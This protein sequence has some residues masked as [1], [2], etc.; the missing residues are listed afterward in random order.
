[1]LENRL[2][3]SQESVPDQDEIPLV[4]DLDGTLVSGDLLFEGLAR[5]VAAAPHRI[6]LL[7]LWLLRGRASLKRR[8]AQAAPLD[9]EELVLSPAVSDRISEAR[10][11]GRPVYLASARFFVPL[12]EF[13]ELLL[14]LGILSFMIVAYIR[15][16]S[17]ESSAD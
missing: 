16:G 1:M 11:A 13:A 12:G 17:A 6:C 2:T 9:P 10:R 4:V 7:P 8:V 14:A 5:L 15:L 3:P